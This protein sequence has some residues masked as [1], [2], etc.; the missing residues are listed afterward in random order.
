MSLSA[1]QFSLGRRARLST[2]TSQPKDLL[3]DY[4]VFF[5]AMQPMSSY[6]LSSLE[7]VKMVVED[8][9]ERD[10]QLGQFFFV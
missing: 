7:L 10:L 4:F 1:L 6:W 5:V 9:K 3:V 8:G 2:G